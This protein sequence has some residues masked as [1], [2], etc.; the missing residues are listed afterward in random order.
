MSELKDFLE[1]VRKSSAK[2][3]EVA[4]KH[5]MQ[6]KDTNWITKFHYIFTLH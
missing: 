4:M 5:V 6:T 1:S 2:I 3:G